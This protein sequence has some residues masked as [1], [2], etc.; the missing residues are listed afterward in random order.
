MENIL[1][2]YVAYMRE[3][4]ISPEKLYKIYF[5]AIIIVVDSLAAPKSWS[6]VFL[7]ARGSSPLSVFYGISNKS[8]IEF[9]VYNNQ[10]TSTSELITQ[11]LT[12]VV[13]FSSGEFEL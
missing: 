10:S 11:L 8:N 12:H 1:M 6:S 3:N 4:A 5:L 2:F 7:I 13:Q 9:R